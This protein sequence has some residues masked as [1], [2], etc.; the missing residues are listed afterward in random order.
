MRRVWV[1]RETDDEQHRQLDLFIWGDALAGA[2]E[3][4]KRVFMQMICGGAFEIPSVTELT[5]TGVP[6]MEAVR[7]HGSTIDQMKA[8]QRWLLEDEPY[9]HAAEAVLKGTTL[10]WD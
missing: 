6:F 10:S 8:Q 5:A 3:M 9:R 7:Q 2:Q 1:P 4:A